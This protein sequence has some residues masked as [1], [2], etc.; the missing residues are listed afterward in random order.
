MTSLTAANSS[1]YWHRELP[2]LDAR[3]L[4]EYAIEADSVHVPDTI[5]GREALWTRCENDLMT[6]A[7]RRLVSEVERLRGRCAHVVGESIEARHNGATGEAWL[8]GHFRYV[9]YR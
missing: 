7:C 2:P 1:V 3:P 9:L 8:R 6:E 4:G 5:S